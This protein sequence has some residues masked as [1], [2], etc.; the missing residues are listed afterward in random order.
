MFREFHSRDLSLFSLNF[1][2]I[3]L[4]PKQQE[5]KKVQQYRPICM[6]NVSFKIFTKEMA[7]RLAL[8]A[9]KLIGQS[10]TAFQRGRNILE[11]VVVLHETLHEVRKKKQSGLILKIDF[12]KAYDKVNWQF[13]QQ[14]LRMK[15][16]SQK[17]C[18]W[19]DQIVSGGSV[20]VLVNDELGHFF[21]TKK[22]LRQGDPLSPLLFN[23]A[24][25]MLAILIERSVKLGHFQGLIPHLV[26]GGVSIL[27]YADDTILFWK[28]I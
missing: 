28:M 14:V 24:A 1:G 3:T 7:N 23:L 11:G 4:I 5:V 19:I 22:G 12:E 25:D 21:Q 2:I 20:G 18:R 6:L 15:G 10:Q 27:Q 13:L 16:F 26:E 8:V 9:S 17:W